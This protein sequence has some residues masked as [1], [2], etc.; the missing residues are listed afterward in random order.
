M[1]Y[2]EEMGAKKPYIIAIIIYT[3]LPGMYVVNK[4]ALDHGMN[5]FVFIFYRQAAACLLLLPVAA[6][7]ERTNVR[8]MSFML[9]LKLFFCALI[10]ITISLNLYNVGL[11]L[12]SATV[13]SASNNSV[14]VVTFCLALLLRIEEFKLRNPAGIAKVTGMALCLAGVFAI[15]FYAGP[16]LRPVNHHR[17][18][19]AATRAGITAGKGAWIEGAFMLLLSV[20]AYSLW[21]VMQA[22]VLKEFPNKMLV[23]VTQCVF[24]AVQSFVVAA[25]AERDFSMWKLRL[26]IGLL[27]IAYS[28]FVVVGVSY[29][30]QA[31]CLEMRGPV[32]LAAWTPFSFVLTM[33]CS[34][35]FLG[36][37]VHLGSIIGGILLS[38][39][40][41]SM[42]W[43]KSKETKVEP[44]S[45]GLKGELVRKA[46]EVA[47]DVTAREEHE[48]ATSASSIEL[49]V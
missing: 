48:E 45:T 42:L 38:G 39:G 5:T 18:F 12:T 40:L 35:F 29:Y 4:A 32:F 9:L 46:P 30:L 36:E 33:F 34:S 10:G 21:I 27:A 37:I 1:F 19:G 22:A 17:A 44:C 16:S 2:A 20:V 31:W 8:S 43:G 26:D 3:M 49:V 14:P 23:T 7:V 47:E 13:A 6:L 25:V 24:S 15:A 28:G 11:K 41:Y